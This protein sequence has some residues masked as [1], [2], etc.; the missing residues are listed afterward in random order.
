MFIEPITGIVR[1]PDSLTFRHYL[2]H[3][4]CALLYEAEPTP[5]TEYFFFKATVLLFDGKVNSNVK[6]IATNCE[7]KSGWI[8]EFKE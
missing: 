5:L 3:F 4:Y 7:K 6:K 1:L 2:K 8:F